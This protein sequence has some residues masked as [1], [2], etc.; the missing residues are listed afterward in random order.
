MARHKLSTGK[1]KKH[2]GAKKVT[3]RRKRV[4][5]SGKVQ[6][7][8]MDGA[9]VGG[10]MILMREGAIVAG[11]FFPQLQ[12]KPVWVGVGQA[13]IGLFA[14]MKGTQ[15]WMRYAGMGAFG[16]GLLTVG[17]GLGIIGGPPATM[18]YDYVNRR[19]GGDPRLQF[20][21]GPETRIGGFPNNFNL[22]AGVG[23]ARKRRYTS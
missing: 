21:A 9:A 8:V 14:A 23:A 2:T 20:I 18:S 16:M 3:H 4:G 1:K 15:G 10:G 22:V 13:A 17:N 7:V 11:H 19:M 5:A 12:A 6:S